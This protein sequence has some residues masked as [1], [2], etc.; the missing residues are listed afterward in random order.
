MLK[1]LPKPG[2]PIIFRASKH[3]T[4]PGPRA[5]DI[6]PTAHG[7][8]YSYQVDKFWVV[9]EAQEDGNLVL[10]TRRGKTRTVHVESP[11]LRKPSLLERW[12][13]RDRFPDLDEL[14]DTGHARQ[15]GD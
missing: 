9:Q 7:D 15:A 12:L 8:D 5:E 14:V 2:D 1:R 11:Q 13:Y 10:R 3:G 4:R 6:H